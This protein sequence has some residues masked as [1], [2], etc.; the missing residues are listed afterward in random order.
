VTA[1]APPE[2]P[3]GARRSRR[4]IVVVAIVAAL[5]VVARLLELFWFQFHKAFI[6]ERV[7]EALP[8][9]VVDAGTGDGTAAPA[10]GGGGVA[11]PDDDIEVVARGEFRP[12]GRYSASGT[13]LLVEFADGRRV[14]RFEGLDVS[15]GPDLRV[16]LSTEPGGYA[17]GAL[18]LGRLKGNQ[19]NQ[20]Y[21][22]P[23]GADLTPFRSVVIWCDRFSTAFGVAE[24]TPAS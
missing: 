14:V 2:V 7:D 13:V 9:A 1:T 15:N 18:E 21:D 20:N 10:A 16:V 17:D 5:A 3:S 11:T 19:G 6:D 24:F 12:L 23:S 8:A 22:V 4:R